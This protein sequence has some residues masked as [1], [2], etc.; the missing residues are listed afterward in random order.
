MSKHIYHIRVSINVPVLVT[1]E[2]EGELSTEELRE[3][4]AESRVGEFYAAGPLQQDNAY[5]NKPTIDVQAEESDIR[6]EINTSWSNDPD[7][8]RV[9][10]IDV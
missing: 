6:G 4:I 10:K 1:V 7:S 3:R 5:I 2:S 8:V 9:E